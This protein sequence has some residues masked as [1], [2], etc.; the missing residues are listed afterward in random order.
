MEK[1]KQTKKDRL[2]ISVIIPVYNAEKH[3]KECLESVCGQTYQDLEIIL[4]NDGSSDRSGKICDEWQKKDSRIRVFH[5]ENGGVSSA[6]NEGLKAASG[7]LIGCVDADD[8]IEPEMY[9]KL[10]EAL[11]AD[12]EADAVFCGYVDYPKGNMELPV[13]KGIRP[14][15]A[16]APLQA[17]IRVYE[18]DDREDRRDD[19]AE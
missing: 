5:K 11:A 16:C 15:K 13:E 3:L 12:P 8:W 9:E 2:L 1:E 17:A 4:V 6:R 10:S 14:S 7:S 19:A 18:R